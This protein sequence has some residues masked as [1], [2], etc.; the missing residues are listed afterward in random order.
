MKF[1]N[2][3]IAAKAKIEKPSLVR[4]QISC[5]IFQEIDG[6]RSFQKRPPLS[7]KSSY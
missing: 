6:N 1:L 4:R 3:Q 2:P 7:N 5:G